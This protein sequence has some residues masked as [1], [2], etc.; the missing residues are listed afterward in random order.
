MA[1]YSISDEKKKQKSI[2]S[3][4]YWQ[5]FKK[6]QNSTLHKHLKK[7]IETYLQAETSIN[8]KQIGKQILSNLNEK[9]LALTTKTKISDEQLSSLYGMILWN[10]IA[11]RDEKWLFYKQEK[12]DPDTTSAMQYFRG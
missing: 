10:T 2:G 4:D 6:H 7:E 5:L 11:E 8:S 12:T 9:I 3:K 1:L